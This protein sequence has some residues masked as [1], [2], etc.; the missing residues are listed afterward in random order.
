MENARAK[1]HIWY[2]KSNRSEFASATTDVERRNIKI[3]D[4]CAGKIIS[5]WAE[6]L[7]NVRTP[8]YEPV[9]LDVGSVFFYCNN[10][11]GRLA[12]NTGGKTINIARLGVKL[13]SLPL[14]N[15][16]AEHTMRIKECRD[17][18]DELKRTS[19]PQ[20]DPALLPRVPVR[21]APSLAD[22]V[23]NAKKLAS[24]HAPLTDSDLRDAVA[25]VIV[26]K[27][28]FRL[29]IDPANAAKLLAKQFFDQP[30][31]IQ[32]SSIS[33]ENW[34]AKWQ[35]FAGALVAN[36]KA[37]SLNSPSLQKCLQALNEGRNQQTI[38]YPIKHEQR[39]D[40]TLSP[41]IIASTK[42]DVE[43][44]YQSALEHWKNHPEKWHNERLAIIPVAA[45]AASSARG[46]CWIIVCKWE[47]SVAGKSL[48][49]RH[50]MAWALDART[51]EVI[52]YVTCD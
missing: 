20:P 19:F 50:V 28:D 18:I 51:S 30:A 45:Y 1:Q 22:D 46:E 17:I 37:R 32:F 12:N 3:S 27:S 10:R 34:H 6:A 33:T 4:H 39:S 38:L 21:T 36:A 5:I 7:R 29:P 42:K 47:Y 41:E 26:E 14:A 35:I 52:A 49:L 24:Y 43:T 40:H 48:P 31:D 11:Y 2:W 15:N 16:E 9:I 8:D 13:W 44:D 25:R 23:S